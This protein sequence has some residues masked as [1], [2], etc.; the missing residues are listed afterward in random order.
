MLTN[1]ERMHA[2]DNYTTTESDKTRGTA[3]LLLSG[4]ENKSLD[5]TVM[6]SF[7]TP[8]QQQIIDI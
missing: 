5:L 8:S 3:K 1:R 2:V 4:G 7:N 6:G